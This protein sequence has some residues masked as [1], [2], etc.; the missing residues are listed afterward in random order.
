MAKSQLLILENELK[1]IKIKRTISA[2]LAFLLS[3]LGAVITS[4]YWIGPFTLLIWFLIG[5]AGY[6]ILKRYYDMKEKQVR[7][8]IEKLRSWKG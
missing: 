1:K 8:Q 5:V 3:Y 7:W 2:I 6:Q 4:H